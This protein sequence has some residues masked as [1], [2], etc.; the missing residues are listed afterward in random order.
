MAYR[1][2]HQSIGHPAKRFGAA[3]KHRVQTIRAGITKYTQRRVQQAVFAAEAPFKGDFP[4]LARRLCGKSV[5]LVLG[6]G[7]ARGISQ[8]GVIRALEE[9]GIQVDIVGGTS[10]GSFVGALYARDVDAVL[11]YGCARNFA[12]RMAR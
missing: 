2:T 6:G 7:G 11:I 5:G 9:E 12:A 8:V 1:S 4:R 10:I 3:V